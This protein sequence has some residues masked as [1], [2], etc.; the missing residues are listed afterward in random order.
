VASNEDLSDFSWRFFIRYS[1]PAGIDAF[2]GKCGL[3]LNFADGVSKERIQSRIY[4]HNKYDC[5]ISREKKTNDECDQ[6]S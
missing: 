2:H 4:Y 6:A 5:P 3:I 1:E